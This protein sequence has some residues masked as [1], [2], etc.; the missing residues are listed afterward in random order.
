M[1]G[2]FRPLLAGKPRQ[3]L[4]YEMFC[5]GSGDQ[6]LRPDQELASV[7]FPATCQVRHR[8][9]EGPSIDPRLEIPGGCLIQRFRRMGNQM[10][11]VA[12]KRGAKQDF[13]VTPLDAQRGRSQGF[14]DCHGTPSQAVVANAASCSA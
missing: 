6:H 2:V 1:G 4:F 9:T 10:G 14:G 12:G 3:C 11:A 5:F 8:F 7:K 13:G